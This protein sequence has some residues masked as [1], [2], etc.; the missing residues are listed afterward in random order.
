MQAI[1]SPKSILICLLI[2]LILFSN[3][4]SGNDENSE[5]IYRAGEDGLVQSEK[6]IESQNSY[7]YAS[8]DQ[9]MTDPVIH[10]KASQWLPKARKIKKLSDDMVTL[11]N[12]LK[13]E[14][15]SEKDLRDAVNRIFYV[16]GKGTDLFEKI[17]KYKNELLAVDSQLYKEFAGNILI[18]AQSFDST[19]SDADKFKK[20]FFKNS[21]P[22]L[23]LNVLSGFNNNIRIAES[24]MIT[25][26]NLKCSVINDSWSTYS[27]IIAQ[28]TK[29]LKAGDEIEVTAGVGSFSKAAKP[30]IIINGRNIKIGDE[31]VAIY[32][33]KASGKPGKYKI[34]AFIN[35]IDEEGYHKQLVSNIEYTIVKE[36]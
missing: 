20:Y 21:P 17:V 22:S 13:T 29:Y 15:K 9:K 35:F 26:C 16:K 2:S 4:C 24:R 14:L 27:A 1:Q 33:L 23:V 12:K 5:N 25:Y 31:G 7:I 19:K 3:S 28:N 11:I 34:P 6:F 8:L 30:D 36:Q 32:K 10:E 18:T